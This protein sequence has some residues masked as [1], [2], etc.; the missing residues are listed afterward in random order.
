MIDSGRSWQIGTVSALEFVTVDQPV[1]LHDVPEMCHHLQDYG[2]GVGLE[3]VRERS[4]LVSG[5][6]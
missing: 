4:A 2:V 5:P 3:P 1:R 6:D